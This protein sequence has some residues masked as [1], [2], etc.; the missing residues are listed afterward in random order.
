MLFKKIYLFKSTW[1]R[2]KI[3]D[4]FHV[5]MTAGLSIAFLIGFAVGMFLP[6][7]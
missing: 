1:P 4:R 7:A 5:Y 2:Q 3:V 6:N